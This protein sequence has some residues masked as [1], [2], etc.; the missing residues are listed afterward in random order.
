MTGGFMDEDLDWFADILLQQLYFTTSNS[1]NGNETLF[2]Q[3]N[4][5]FSFYQKI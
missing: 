5:V 4:N 2:S 1:V 3:N